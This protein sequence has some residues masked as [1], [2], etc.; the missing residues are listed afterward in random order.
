MHGFRNQFGESALL[1]RFYGLLR[2]AAG[3]CHAL[4]AH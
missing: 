1:K 3:R 2:G 4:N